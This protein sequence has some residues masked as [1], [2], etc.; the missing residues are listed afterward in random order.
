MMSNAVRVLARSASS[1]AFRARSRSNS[2]ASADRPDQLCPWTVSSIGHAFQGAGIPGPSP[3]DHMRRVQALPA[4]DRAFLAVRR[5][6]ILGEN[7]QLVLRTERATRGTRRGTILGQR[8]GRR[9]GLVPSAAG[10]TPLLVDTDTRISDHALRWEQPLG[11]LSH[12]I[13]T[14]SFLVRVRLGLAIT[15]LAGRTTCSYPKAAV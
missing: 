8:T 14:E 11:K 4:Q 1:F 10:I 6:L 7:T 15:R 3:F 5:R 2:T 12:V 9:W 13:L